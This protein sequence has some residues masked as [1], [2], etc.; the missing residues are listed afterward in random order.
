VRHAA[1][2]TGRQ[3]ERGLG[4]SFGLRARS[5]SR[6]QLAIDQCGDDGAQKRR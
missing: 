1:G 5:E 4:E 6:D 3:I 2:A